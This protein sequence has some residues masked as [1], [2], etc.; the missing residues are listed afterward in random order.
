MLESLCERSYIPSFRSLA[1]GGWTKLRWGTVNIFSTVGDRKGIFFSFLWH[2]LL[3]HCHVYH[4]SS[5]LSPSSIQKTETRDRCSVASDLPQLHVARYDCV[6]LLADLVVTKI[7]HQF[8][9]SHGSACFISLLL[10]TPLMS[11][12]L[13]DKIW[14]N[15]GKSMWNVQPV[16]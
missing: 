12:V 1:T 14:W 4:K 3:K 11:L 7:L 13:S 6:L 9:T 8:I 5:V 10:Y 2:T 15:G 16:T